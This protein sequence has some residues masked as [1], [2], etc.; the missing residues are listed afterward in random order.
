MDFG[1]VPSDL[2]KVVPKK[3]EQWEETVKAESLDLPDRVHPQVTDEQVRPQL[4]VVRGSVEPVSVKEYRRGVL[5]LTV[6]DW[7]GEA[8]GLRVHGRRHDPTRH[9][10]RTTCPS[11]SPKSPGRT[12]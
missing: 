10:P 11:G 3:E 6:R 4:P 2:L 1:E 7:G 9:L 5:S 8:R 12:P